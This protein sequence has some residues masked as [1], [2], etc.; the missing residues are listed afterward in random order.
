MWKAISVAGVNLGSAID[1][2][3][4]SNFM[5]IWTHVFAQIALKTDVCDIY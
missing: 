2:N 3:H 1:F 4:K 5:T